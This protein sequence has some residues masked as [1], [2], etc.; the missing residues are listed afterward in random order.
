MLDGVIGL[1][2][3]GFDF[4][5]RRFEG[6]VGPV[7]KQRVCRRPADALVEQDEHECGLDALV[8]ESVAVASS[9]AFEQAVCFH[10]SRVIA[11]LGEC[12]G[13]GGEAESSEDSLMDVGGS[14]PVKL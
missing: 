2:M 12:V 7:M 10:L 5:G 8:G 3:G 14:P 9:D 1:V 6:F 13:A 4:A 11:E